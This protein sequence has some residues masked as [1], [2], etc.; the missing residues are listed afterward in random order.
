MGDENKRQEVERYS[1][2]IN[3]KLSELNGVVKEARDDGI[4][5]DFDVIDVT[6]HDSP[7]HPETIVHADV[8]AV[9]RP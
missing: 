5:V 3:Q 9:L 8:Y 4:T 2:I 7:Q 6:S 1:A